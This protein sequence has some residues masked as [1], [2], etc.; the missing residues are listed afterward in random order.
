M[1]IPIKSESMGTDNDFEIALDS[2]SSD[3]LC[4]LW[5][6]S[7]S[8]TDGDGRDDGLETSA[9]TIPTDNSS[10]PYVICIYNDCS[11]LCDTTAMNVTDDKTVDIGD[12]DAVCYKLCDDSI[13]E[14]S[15]Q[16]GAGELIAVQSGC[17]SLQK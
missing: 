16:L 1:P 4:T 13:T 3:P 6:A 9:G 17:L 7:D 2:F 14:T 10:W 15:L 8:D 5:I 12:S 11:G